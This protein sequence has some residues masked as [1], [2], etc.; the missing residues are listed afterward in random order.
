MPQGNPGITAVSFPFLDRGFVAMRKFSHSLFLLLALWATPLLAQ[1]KPSPHFKS[2]THPEAAA[3]KAYVDSTIAAAIAASG[4]VSAASLGILPTNTAVANSTAIAAAFTAFGAVGGGEIQF[5][6]GTYLFTQIDNNVPGVLLRGQNIRPPTDAGTNANCV[7]F[8]AT[9]TGTFFKHRTPY[10]ANRAKYSGGGFSGITFNANGFATRLIEVDT[11][12][13]G[14]YIGSLLNAVGSEAAWFKSGLSGS[15][16]ADAADIQGASINLTC[17]QLDGTA[18]QNASCYKLDGSTNSNFSYN[19][20][21]KLRC[22]IYNGNCLQGVNADNNR[23][24]LSSY[25]A[26]GGTGYTAYIYGGTAGFRNNYFLHFGGN[27]PT[28][29]QGTNDGV[30]PVSNEIAF[31]DNDNGTPVPLAGTG[32]QWHGEFRQTYT[33]TVTCTSGTLSSYTNTG[34]QFVRRKANQ[35][36][37]TFETFLSDVGTCTGDIQISLPSTA[38][39][40]VAT[41][42]G[43]ERAATGRSLMITI[44]PG[45]NVMR[46]TNIPAGTPVNPASG[47]V[48]SSTISY[49]T[50]P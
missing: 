41:G 39:S 12:N 11:V 19:D 27:A 29:A 3:N 10:H 8:V 17:R 28:Y 13:F 22:Q 47:W 45:E 50:I 38:S 33:P 34:A 15:D 32:S 6:C 1:E 23:I 31:F 21:V 36:W 46:L 30:T 48:V 26:A 25:R 42:V 5:T 14:T 37:L 9:Q 40:S 4:R 49:L 2:P 16:V 20:D 24:M 35:I 7:Q 18:A 43:T 44:L